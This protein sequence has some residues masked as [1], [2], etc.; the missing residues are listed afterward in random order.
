MRLRDRISAILEDEDG[1]GDLLTLDGLPECDL[2]DLHIDAIEEV[3]Q[4]RISPGGVVCPTCGGRAKIYKYK[5]HRSAALCL[6]ALVKNFR[7]TGDWAHVRDIT[8]RGESVASRGGHLAK[9]AL[10]GLAEPASNDDTAKRTSGMWKPTERGILFVDKEIRVP[11]RVL[12]Y[13]GVPL[14]WSRKLIGIDEALGDTLNY[15]ELME[16]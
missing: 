10:W 3:R 8:I 14:K 4:G 5:F 16:E 7:L 2:D 11:R 9:T 13:H 1:F 15:E 6:I 12:L